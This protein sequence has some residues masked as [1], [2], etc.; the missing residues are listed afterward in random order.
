[1]RMKQRK[2]KT[3]SRSPFSTDLS[4]LEDV[5]SHRK[6]PKQQRNQR[7]HSLSNMGGPKQVDHVNEPSGPSVWQPNDDVKLKGDVPPAKEQVQQEIER[8]VFHEGVVHRAIPGVEWEAP[9]DGEV[10]DGKPKVLAALSGDE[11]AHRPDDV[12]TETEEQKKPRVVQESH[13]KMKMKLKLKLKLNKKM[14]KKDE[15]EEEV[16]GEQEERRIRRWKQKRKKEQEGSQPASATPQESHP[17]SSG[18]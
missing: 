11:D 4:P 15:D 17:E 8:L 2:E 18:K 10:H 12:D 5:N 3:S 16:E 6:D 1:M 13:L 7:N 14:K 9:D